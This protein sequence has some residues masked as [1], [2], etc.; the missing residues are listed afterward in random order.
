MCRRK[1]SG[2]LAVF[3]G[4]PV[5]MPVTWCPRDRVGWVAGDETTYRVRFGDDGAIHASPM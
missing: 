2:G 1:L 4:G 5:R 3:G